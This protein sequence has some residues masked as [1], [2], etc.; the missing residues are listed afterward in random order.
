MLFG[1]ARIAASSADVFDVQTLAG[2]AGQGQRRSQNL[3]SSFTCAAIDKNSI[4]LTNPVVRKL[5]YKSKAV[6][7]LTTIAYYD[8]IERLK[9]IRQ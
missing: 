1:Q 8:H 3:A 9:V 6:F 2:D 7:S 5:F 4:H